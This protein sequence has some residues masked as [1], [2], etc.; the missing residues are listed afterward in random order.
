MG[1]AGLLE[2]M[3][4]TVDMSGQW[5]LVAVTDDEKAKAFQ[6]KFGVPLTAKFRHMPESF[7]RLL[8]KIG[9]CNLLTMLEFRRFQ[10]DLSALH[11]GRPKKSVIRRRRHV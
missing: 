3:P 1:S 10:A 7:A 9:Y 4:D 6:G 2:G 11:R 8:A 5:Q